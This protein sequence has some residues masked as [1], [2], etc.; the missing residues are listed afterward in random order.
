MC[1][2]FEVILRLSLKP[3]LVDVDPKTYNIN[4]EFISNAIASESKIIIP[5][6]LFGRPCEMYQIMEID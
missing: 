4:P 1:Y 5:V 6:H 2:F 3:I